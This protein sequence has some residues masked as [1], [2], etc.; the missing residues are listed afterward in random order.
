MA[1]VVELAA[2]LSRS[3]N[4]RCALL[5]ILVVRDVSGSAKPQAV[6]FW[7]Y[8]RDG[9]LDGGGKAGMIIQRFIGNDT[10]YR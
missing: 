2:W 4:S 10:S 1:F 5:A 7:V 8:G 9:P 6:K 3:S